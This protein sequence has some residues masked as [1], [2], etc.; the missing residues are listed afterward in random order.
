MGSTAVDTAV[1]TA[2]RKSRRRGARLEEAIFRATWEELEASGW[3]G[4][5]MEKVAVRA[6]T[7]KQPIYRRWPNRVALATAT[8]Q[9]MA[10]LGEGTVHPTGDLRADL[11]ALL[12]FHVDTLA[13]PVG[14]VARGLVSEIGSGDSGLMGGGLDRDPAGIVRE[15]FDAALA[16]GAVR[17]DA[18]TADRMNLG[19]DLVSHHFLR[20]GAVPDEPTLV[21]ILDDIWMPLLSRT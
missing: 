15:V 1:D 13:G 2:V 12:R 14:H 6:G 9:Y 8:L 21:R 10:Q 4:F 16:S 7:G 17:E 20:T 5:T 18:L 19:P 3:A 11:L